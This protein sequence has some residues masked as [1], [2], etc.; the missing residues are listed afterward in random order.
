MNNNNSNENNALINAYSDSVVESE[1][2]MKTYEGVYIEE[3]TLCSVFFRAKDRNSA[4]KTCKRLGLGLKGESEGFR[5][6][7]NSIQPMF[8]DAKT[9]MNL[10]GGISRSTLY[11]ELTLANLQRVPG[12]RKILITLDSIKKWHR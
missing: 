6:K 1:R 10:L 7:H 3:S 5:A 12:T 9:A 11:K 8:C 4:L 2:D